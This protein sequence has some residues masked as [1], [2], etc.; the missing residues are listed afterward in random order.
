MYIPCERDDRSVETE[1]SPPRFRSPPPP[2][3]VAY[4]KNGYG[5]TVTSANKNH[6][7][8]P[9][10]LLTI[11]LTQHEVK[12]QSRLLEKSHSGYVLGSAEK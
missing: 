4:K 2:P 12:T 5:I 7:Q 1:L 10:I 3:V 8:D 9:D 6:D 11:L